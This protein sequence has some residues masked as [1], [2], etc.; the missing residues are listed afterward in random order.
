MRRV[1]QRAIKRQLQ[2]REAEQRRRKRKITSATKSELRAARRRYTRGVNY[3]PSAHAGAGH[4]SRTYQS[5][6]GAKREREAQRIL[7]KT[8]QN[9]LA[10]RLGLI[11]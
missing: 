2:E 8:V 5:F 7:A 6:G 1:R 10:K 11:K 3:A 4:G 9:T